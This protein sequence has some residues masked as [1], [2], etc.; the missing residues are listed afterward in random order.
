VDP[1]ELHRAYV[2]SLRLIVARERCTHELT[3]RLE[4][5]GYPAPVVTACIGRLAEEG[6]LDDRRFASSFVIAKLDAGWGVPRITR[7]LESRGIPIAGVPGWPEEYITEDEMTRAREVL[8]ASHFTSK[9]LKAS[10][11]RKLVSRGFSSSVASRCAWEY[12]EAEHE[13]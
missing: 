2:H 12:G 11:Y 3:K 5:D 13:R 1:S 6:Y 8:A 9:N 10:A 7:E 4:R